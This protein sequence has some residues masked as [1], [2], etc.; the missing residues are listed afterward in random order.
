MNYN[1]DLGQSDHVRLVQVIS[2][3]Q[4]LFENN[5]KNIQTDLIIMDFAKAFDKV[6]HKRL[7][8]KMKYFGI[9]DQIINWVEYTKVFHFIQ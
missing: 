9:S 3:M 1:M 7:L 4:E 5:D 8:Y 2:L 6:Q